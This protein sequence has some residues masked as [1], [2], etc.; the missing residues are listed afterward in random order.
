M[1]SGRRETGHVQPIK[2]TRLQLGQLEARLAPAVVA[3]DATANVHAIDPNIYGTGL[4]QHRAVDRSATCRSTATAATRR[5]PTASRRTQPTAAATGSS[6]ASAGDRATARG[7]TTGSTRPWP[8]ARSRA[9]RST[10][11]TGRLA[12][13]AN[14]DILGSFSVRTSTGHSNRLTRGSTN[15]GNGVR[16]N[17]TQHHRQRPER[18]PTS[19][20]SPAIEQAWIQHLID[21]FGN[22]QNGGVQY[23][24]LGNEPGL[25]HH[26]HRDIH[27]NGNTL[28][29]TARPRHRLRVDGQVARPERQD[30]R[31]RGVGLDAT[32]SSAARTRPPGTGARPTTD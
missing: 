32:T 14:R 30:P 23:Y 27:P 1:T 2:V 21:T 8:A 24:T 7:W 18:S 10:C 6:R 12:N 20:N 26:T 29:G 31:L 15:L 28:H 9:S 4:R 5:T 19:P 25:W 3:V 16:T 13:A 22:S 11:S 17:G